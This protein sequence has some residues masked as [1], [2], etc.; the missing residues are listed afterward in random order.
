MED[1]ILATPPFFSF[2]QN[3]SYLARSADECLY[4]IENGSI[5][6]WID[7]GG[8]HIAVEIS[9]AAG[10]AALRIRF[11]EQ[12]SPAGREGAIRF[13]REWFDM[14][15][16]LAPFYAMARQDHLLQEAAV[17]FE[18]LRLIGIP[19][20][21]E[22]VCW[23]IL[24]QQ[25][26][27]KFAYTLKKRFVERFGA[28]TE[29]EGHTLWLFPK[30]SVVMELQI[31]DLTAMQITTRK[32]EY[33]IG[34]AGLME[35]GELSKSAL[36]AAGGLREAEKQLVCIRGIGPWT[37]N[38]ALMRCL[39]MTNAFPIDDVGLHLAIKH[40]LGLPDKPPVKQ[41]RE[42]TTG[43]SGWES[44]ATFYMWKTLY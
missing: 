28:H 17:R 36:I 21:F 34:V 12:P 26:N 20:L 25:I 32:A 31:E 5:Y 39:R 43:W 13:I 37:A 3:L 11:R 8:E 24:G 33:M 10:E 16:D 44:Y 19:D 6:R 14:D 30:P 15:R 23:G 18:G 4:R 41:I 35:A 40:R 2:S 27:L 29:W 9:E 1:V 22:A 7:A 42:I 38:Y